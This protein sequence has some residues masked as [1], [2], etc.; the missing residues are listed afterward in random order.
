MPQPRK[1]LEHHKFH[2]TKPQYVEPQSDVAA[3][4]PK[5]PS[6]ISAAAKA[7]FKRL[8]RLLEHRR[9]CTAGDAEILRLY[10]V[11][12]DRHTRALEH[13][14]SEGEIVTY[15]RL[16]NHGEQVPSVKPNLWLD[17]ATNAEK[18]M[19][20]CLADLGLNPLQRS[21]VAPTKAEPKPE[22]EIATR[23]ETTLPEDDDIDLDS[24]DTTAG[25][26]LQ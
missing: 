7:T 23:E 15:L 18:F 6:N 26:T 12:F 17:V 2:N 14:A 13:L 1:S 4:R 21:K 24:I 22:E 3:G 19:R 10:A 5:Y 20:A 9:V 16:N 11:T 8:V 25:G